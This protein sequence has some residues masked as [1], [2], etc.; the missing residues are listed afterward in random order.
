MIV[1]MA[2]AGLIIPEY[3]FVESQIQPASL[4]LRLGNVAYRVRASFLPGPHGT[5][6]RRIADLK[7]HEIPL[8]NGAVLETGC[9]YIVPLQE[10]LALPADVSAS[11]N[12]KSSTG[13][14]D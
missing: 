1:A 6:G 4:D 9:V 11:A 2:E 7:V 13:R 14:L 10:S 5:V 8:S 12:P 3:D